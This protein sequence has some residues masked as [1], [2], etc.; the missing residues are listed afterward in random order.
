VV[1][2]VVEAGTVDRGK[3]GSKEK[4]RPVRRLF[5]LVFASWYNFVNQFF[6]CFSLLNFTVT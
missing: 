4:G 5:I 6:L 3:K 1:V 2:P